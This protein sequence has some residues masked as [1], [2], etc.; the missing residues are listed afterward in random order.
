[1]GA[2]SRIPF[3]FTNKADIFRVECAQK[4]SSYWSGWP[5]KMHKKIWCLSGWHPERHLSKIGLI[6]LVDWHLFPVP[7]LDVRDP[8]DGRRRD[9]LYCWWFPFQSWVNWWDTH[10]LSRMPHMQRGPRTRLGRSLGVLRRQPWGRDLH[11][12]DTM[13]IRD[14]WST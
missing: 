1:M 10:M 6:D 14:T 12:A 8:G 7:S 4:A 9:G 13:I 2:K 3:D 5:K 11:I